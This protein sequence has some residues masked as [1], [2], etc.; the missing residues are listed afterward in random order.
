M[1]ICPGWKTKKDPTKEMDREEALEQIGKKKEN[2]V[3]VLRKRKKR[4]LRKKDQQD[5]YSRSCRGHITT[6]FFSDAALSSFSYLDTYR[7]YRI[8]NIFCY[9]SRSIFQ[10]LLLKCFWKLTSSPIL[11]PWAWSPPYSRS[12]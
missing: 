3:K 11:L 12:H 7:Y 1:G 5:H 2:K 9:Y 10:I 4:L 6:L 8:L